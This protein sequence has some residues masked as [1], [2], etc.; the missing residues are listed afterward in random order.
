MEVD[1][2]DLENLMKIVEKLPKLAPS[3]QMTPIPWP[4]FSW[5]IRAEW[6][7]E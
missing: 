4:H 1:P 7:A 2:A 5:Y 3:R 6:S